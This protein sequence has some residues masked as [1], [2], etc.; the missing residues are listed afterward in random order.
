MR[1]ERAWD[2]SSPCAASIGINAK[3]YNAIYLRQG[4]VCA[5]CGEKPTTK[6]LAVDHA[7]VHGLLCS[8]CN[9]ALGAFKGDLGLLSKAYEYL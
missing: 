7:R 2:L 5:I 8:R 6:R 4:G 9:T 3:D 1:L